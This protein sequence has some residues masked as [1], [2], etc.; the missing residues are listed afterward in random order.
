MSGD[1]IGDWLGFL[2]G[3]A[4]WL[5]NKITGRLGQIGDS[6][7]AKMLI[8]M[9][10]KLGSAALDKLK[11]LMTI[12]SDVGGGGNM[13]GGLQAGI[14]GVL[15]AL[16]GAFG[17]V[18]VI[19]GYRPG[20]RTL[21]GNVSYH[22]S[23]RAID[24]APVKAWAAFLNGAFGPRLRELITPWQQYN[25]HNGRPHTYTGA[26]W[27]QHNFAGGNAHIHA[28]MDDGGMRYLRPGLNLIPNGTG[29]PE[30]IYGPAGIAE[31]IGRIDTLIA[32]TARLAPEFGREIGTMGSRLHSA[33]RRR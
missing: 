25:I 11:S 22:A 21:T 28:A 9:G 18:S 1:G 17:N 19:S 29:A 5:K 10:K 33:A 24:I 27:N 3:P 30:P 2:K 16:R 6:P 4:N 26:V 31:L 12:G 7:F 8:G 14:R 15:A 23:G 20:S 13:I 32:V